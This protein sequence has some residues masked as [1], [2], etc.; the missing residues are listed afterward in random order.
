[1]SNALGLTLL[2]V[3]IGGIIL[4][5]VVVQYVANHYPET[6]IGQICKAI[7]EFIVRLPGE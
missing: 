2:G 3:L 1:M 5:V 4:F 7:D 6:R